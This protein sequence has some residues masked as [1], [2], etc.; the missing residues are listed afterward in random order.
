MEFFI[1]LARECSHGS[2]GSLNV[3][4]V[5]TERRTNVVVSAALITK[6]DESINGDIFLHK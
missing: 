1:I 4:N 3:L 6:R 2:H 5:E